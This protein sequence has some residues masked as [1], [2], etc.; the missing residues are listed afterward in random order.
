MAVNTLKSSESQDL[1]EILM[2]L[3]GNAP[4]NFLLMTFGKIT[5]GY[6][7]FPLSVS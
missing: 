6:L 2:L 4:K 3:A 7:V 5:L 1:S